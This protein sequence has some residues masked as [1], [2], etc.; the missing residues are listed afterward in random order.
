MLI[1]SSNLH[2]DY[3]DLH[4]HWCSFSEDFA[5]G[6][7][8]LSAMRANWMVVGDVFEEDFWHAG[9]RL[10]VVFH[11]TLERDQDKMVMP[12]MS[13]PYVRRLIRDLNIKPQ[14]YQPVKPVEVQ[15]EAEA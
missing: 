3:P 13:N 4:R 14:R 12:V 7:A 9:T 10:V 2:V 5:G 8:L 6:D 11:F 15:A 1:K